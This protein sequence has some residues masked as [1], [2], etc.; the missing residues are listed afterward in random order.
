M[1]MDSGSSKCFAMDK[2]A[3]VWHVR[4]VQDNRLMVRHWIEIQEER[5]FFVCFVFL[6]E[7]A[8]V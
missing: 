7:E 5:F 2:C 8:N 3:R 4:E 6:K 1:Q